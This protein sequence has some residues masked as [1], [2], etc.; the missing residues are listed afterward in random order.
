MP[1]RS[2]MTYSIKHH[3]LHLDAVPVAQRPTPNR[4]GRMTP[5]FLV[6]HFTGSSSTSSAV[7][8]LTD[9]RA[10]ASAHLVISPEG[11]VTQLAPFNVIT[12][13]AGRSAYQGR[14]GFNSFSI[15]IELVNAGMLAKRADGVFIERISPKVVPAD[16]VILARHKNGGPE[17]P[18]AIYPQA[19]I[20]ASIEIGQALNATY[21]FIEVVGHDEIAPGRKSDP[22]AAF[23]MGRVESLI[24]GR[25]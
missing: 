1:A 4:G 25:R 7:G 13:H 24:M 10:K 14:E 22:G 23:P 21:R 5:Q 8:W 3:I 9:A 20:E 18:W 12:W 15:G 11:A 17:A 2:A 19:Q 6:M 16:Q